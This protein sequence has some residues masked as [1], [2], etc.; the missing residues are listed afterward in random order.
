MW[1]VLLGGGVSVHVGAKF[2][3]EKKNVM[4]LTLNILRVSAVHVSIISCA[5][6]AGLRA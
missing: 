5:G 2:G 4:K 1:G 6:W 3:V